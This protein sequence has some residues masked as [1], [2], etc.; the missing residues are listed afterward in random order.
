M[1]R[2]PIHIV[3]ADGAGNIVVSGNATFYEYKAADPS[4]PDTIATIY[5]NKTGGSAVASG[6]IITDSNGTA[7]AWIDDGDYSGASL[8]TLITSK[9]THTDVPFHFSVPG[10]SFKDA[11]E[12][13]TNKTLISPV[14][15]TPQIDDTSRDHQYIFAVNE[16]SADRTVTLPLLVGNDTFVFAAF[17]Q[18]LTNKTLTSPKI[19]TSILDTNGNELFKLI[20]TSSAINEIT[21]AN[22]AASGNPTFTAS[23]GDTHIGINLV[24]KGTGLLQYSGNRLAIIN[25]VFNYRVGLNCKQ[26]SATTV[27]IDAGE[28]IVDGMPVRKQ[29]T[30]TIALTTAGD[31]VDN[32]SHQATNTDFY[33]YI[34][35]SRTIEFDDQAPD[36]SDPDDNTS[37]ILRYNNTGTDTSWR[38]CIGFLRTNG[39]G[40]GELGVGSVLSFDERFALKKYLGI[41]QASGSGTAID[42]TSIPAGTRKITIM[43]VGVSTDGTEELLI[44]IGD[45]GGIE[46]S[47]YLGG[48]FINGG[49]VNE[50]TGF[51]IVMTGAAAGIYH[52]AVV[53]SLE[54]SA[55]FT[56]VSSSNISRSD[57]TPSTSGSGSKSLSAELTQLRITTTGTP[58]DFDAGAINI[59]Y[60]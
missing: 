54:N 17:I 4:N 36:A 49:S 18:T 48:A 40:S 8:F 55:A 58:D 16:L 15:V 20:A 37:G 24:P 6:I 41:E 29:T 47:G 32:A 26:A 14:L 52:G 31:W 42:F 30:T 43:L 10:L 3:Y 56:W 25:D 19:G 46:T 35:S 28:I 23:G 2:I 1:A 44:Q 5:E 33:I 34:N 57:A 27:T 7:L 22:A 13:L 51:V 38:R 21:Y 59:Q 9:S 11:V 53:L 45:A 39:T 50:T 12:E 60:E